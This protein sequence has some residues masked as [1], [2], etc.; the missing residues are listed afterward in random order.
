MAHLGSTT[1]D[2]YA[3]PLI[4]AFT[5]QFVGLRVRVGLLLVNKAVVLVEEVPVSVVLV[6]DV[7][8]S[9]IFVE[10]RLIRLLE[11]L[12]AINIFGLLLLMAIAKLLLLLVMSVLY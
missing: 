10:F 9:D 4:L 1:A 8:Y 2:V 5:V 12:A 11:S 6:E 7:A 3:I